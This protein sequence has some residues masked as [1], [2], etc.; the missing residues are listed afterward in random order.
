MKDQGAAIDRIVHS[1]ATKSDRIRKLGELG[2]ARADIARALGVRYQFV[3]NVLVDDERRRAS[4]RED[5]APYDTSTAPPRHPSSADG[6]SRNPGT[7]APGDA[8]EGQY[9]S[10]PATLAIPDTPSTRQLPPA[11]TVLA[12]GGQLTIPE[13]VRISRSLIELPKRDRVA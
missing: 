13:L 2:L 5:P 11:R 3:R 9:T 8:V 12:P 1:D 6:A 7:G 10:A 4:L